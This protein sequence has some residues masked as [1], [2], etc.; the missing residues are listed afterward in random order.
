MTTFTTSDDGL[1]FLIQCP[2]CNASVVVFK[3]EVN[4][5][6]FRHGVYKNNGQQ[7]NPHLSKKECDRVSENGEIYGCGKPFKF[8][9]TSSPEICDYI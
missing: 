5:T 4:C 8:N 3:N 7:L 9:G 1:A 2:H 6:I